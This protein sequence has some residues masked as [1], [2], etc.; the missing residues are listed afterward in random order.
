[1]TIASSKLGSW[2]EREEMLIYDEE[3]WLIFVRDHLG[4]GHISNHASIHQVEG[5][6]A[7]G[8]KGDFYGYLR[9]VNADPTADEIH[10][11]IN[12][13]A[14]PAEWDEG[15]RTIMLLPNGWISELYLQFSRTG[16]KK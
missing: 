11:E 9:H 7:Y 15:H 14:H 1:M 5:I 13:M 16:A 6:S 12:G 4:K 10:L 2:C 3:E 8:Y